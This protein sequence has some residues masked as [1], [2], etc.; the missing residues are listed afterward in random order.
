MTALVALLLL[1]AFD[2]APPIVR[3]RKYEWVDAAN[4]LKMVDVERL[5]FRTG[6]DGTAVRERVLVRTEM[7]GA[8]VPLSPGVKAEV[9]KGD[10]VSED[11]LTARIDRIAASTAPEKGGT[12]QT[13]FEKTPRLP[14][15]AIGFR[16]L[17][18]GP[19][20]VIASLAY[21]EAGG[22][23][24]KGRA[25]FGKKGALVSFSAKG[26]GIRM[27]GSQV[28]AEL[29]VTEGPEGKPAPYKA[30]R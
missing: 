29:T 28:I 10:E 20:K 6:A 4:D 9:L 15:G 24:L 22:L 30:E 19:D 14:Q 17:L 25:T 21:G 1:P 12:W 18:A 11:A 7:D 5:T 26:S 27:P 8:K 23:E 2:P 13:D 3:E 16:S